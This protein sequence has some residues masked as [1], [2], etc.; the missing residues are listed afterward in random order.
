MEAKK[1]LKDSTLTWTKLKQSQITLPTVYQIASAAGKSYD[2]SKAE[3]FSIETEWLVANLDIC[4]GD[5]ANAHSYWTTQ[6]TKIDGGAKYVRKNYLDQDSV[7]RFL[8]IRPVI[9]IPKSQLG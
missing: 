9:T 7:K 4:T 1:Y 8:G 6:P 2:S 3:G 5:G